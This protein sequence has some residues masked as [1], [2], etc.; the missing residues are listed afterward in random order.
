MT[1]YLRKEWG[2]LNEVPSD[3]EDDKDDDDNDANGKD[4]E[5]VEVGTGEAVTMLGRLV[6]LKYLS[7]EEKNSLLIIKDKLETI[8][9]LNKRQSDINDYFMLE[10]SLYDRFTS[11]YFVLKHFKLHH[12][13]I[14]SFFLFFAQSDPDF[15]HLRPEPR[16]SGMPRINL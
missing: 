14:I 4:V 12:F 8:R 11:S 7:K 1:E 16:N 9:V 15:F 5:V 10:K 6:N 2:D 3:N 13:N